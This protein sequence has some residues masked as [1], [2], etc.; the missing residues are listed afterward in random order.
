M[1]I[2]I[3]ICL[4]KRSLDITNVT[5]IGSKIYRSMKELSWRTVSYD[6]V[7]SPLQKSGPGDV[8]LYRYDRFYRTQSV[9]KEDTYVCVCLHACV[10]VSLIYW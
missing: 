5:G 8:L 4:L 10:C 3:K 2:D 6:R 1:W 9:D 7:V